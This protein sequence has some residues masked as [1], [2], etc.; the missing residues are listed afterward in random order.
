MRWDWLSTNGP[1]RG[2]VLIPGPAIVRWISG[3]LFRLACCLGSAHGNTRPHSSTGEGIGRPCTLGSRKDTSQICLP[4]SPSPSWV[5]CR[6]PTQF[7]KVE[8]WILGR[9]TRNICCWA[10]IRS[11]LCCVI[12]VDPLPGERSDL[13]SKEVII[14][15]FTV[16]L[17]WLN[18]YKAR[19]S[20]ELSERAR[21]PQ[22]SKIAQW[23]TKKWKLFHS[24]FT[25]LRRG[26]K[27]SLRKLLNL[28]VLNPTP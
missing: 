21:R 17:K 23:S 22:S 10:T 3:N 12:Q 20:L 1:M 18:D 15:A 14:R 8:T 19:M 4:H 28:M 6:F 2:L 9:V 11:W 7:K 24:I 13:T 5:L 27:L 16:H 25:P 26:L